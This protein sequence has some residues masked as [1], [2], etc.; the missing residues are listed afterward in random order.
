MQR[1]FENLGNN[2]LKYNKDGENHVLNGILFEIYFDSKGDFRN[3][4]KR[5]N[6]D[7][8][9]LLRKNP[10]FAKSFGFIGDVLQPY[11]EQLFY[12]PT[13]HDEPIDIDIN[14]EEEKNN[15][16]IFEDE[17]IQVIHKVNVENKDITRAFSRRC[18]HS[19]DELGV[20]SCLS[21]FLTAPLDLIQIHSNIS[22][23]N[24]AFAKELFNEDLT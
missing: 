20:K 6:F 12:I 3:E 21:N 24:I 16:S 7:S 10:I 18:N 14:A 15:S 17:T 2:L 1:F 19:I 13:I 11:K 4:L 8:V 22:L 9:F 5:H 23:Q